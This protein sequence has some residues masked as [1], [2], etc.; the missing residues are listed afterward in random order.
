[1]TTEQ[2]IRN[3]LDRSLVSGF[4]GRSQQPQMT[5]GIFVREWQ[6]SA[7]DDESTVALI[8]A[9]CQTHTKSETMVLHNGIYQN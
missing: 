4:D 2:F 6:K 9:H 8:E 7:G 5:L 1:M 3:R